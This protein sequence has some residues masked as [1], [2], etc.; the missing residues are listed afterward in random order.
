MHVLRQSLWHEHIDILYSRVV[1]QLVTPNWNVKCNCYSFRWT[2]YILWC[3]LSDICCHIISY[4]VCQYVWKMKWCC[5]RP[6]LCTLFRI[7]WPS[8][9]RGLWGEINDETWPWVV[10]N[11]RSSDQMSITLPLIMHKHIKE[12][13]ALQWWDTLP[14]LWQLTHHQLSNLVLDY[15]MMNR[16]MQT[17]FIPETPL[18]IVIC[19]LSLERVNGGINQ[20]CSHWLIGPTHHGDYTV[21][22]DLTHFCA[23]NQCLWPEV[24]VEHIVTSQG[25]IWPV[26]HYMR[27]VT[28]FNKDYA[29]THR[30]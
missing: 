8:K 25:L 18:S 20:E 17:C 29:M 1:F 9:R 19:H 5:C 14:I 23:Q 2:K 21:T 7:N 22:W 6:H 26:F 28:C 15:A 30:K 11:Q 16:L 3:P 12:W 27:C 24:V 10:L 4:Y 13:Y